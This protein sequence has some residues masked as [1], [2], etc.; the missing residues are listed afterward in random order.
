MLV[1]VA[2]LALILGI[3]LNTHWWASGGAPQ[4][5]RLAGSGEPYKTLKNL[6]RLS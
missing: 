5:K 6:I 1:L 4:G 2:N 3:V